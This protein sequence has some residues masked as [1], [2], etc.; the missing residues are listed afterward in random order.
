[1]SSAFGERNPVLL[2]LAL[3]L[4]VPPLSRLGALSV[5]GTL[6]AA[7]A[8]WLG[9]GPV[10]FVVWAIAPLALAIYVTQGAHFAG[11]GP[12]VLLDLAYAPI[13]VLWKMTAGTKK[14]SG[15]WVRTTRNSEHG[16]PQGE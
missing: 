11:V 2:D 14:S 7:A 9:A 8:W 13:Y 1:V 16:G 3:D 5:L 4:Y 15:A 10:S 12:R 6:V